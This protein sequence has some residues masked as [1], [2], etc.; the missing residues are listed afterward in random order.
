MHQP[1]VEGILR[2]YTNNA[3]NGPRWSSLTISTLLGVKIAMLTFLQNKKGLNLYIQMENKTALPYLMKM[4]GTKKTFLLPLGKEIWKKI[5]GSGDQSYRRITSG[6][7]KC[8]SRLRILEPCGF[9]R[10]EI[11]LASISENNIDLFPTRDR[12]VCNTSDLWNSKMSFMEARPQF[13]KGRCFL[14]VLRKIKGYAF[15][16]FSLIDSFQNKIGREKC[17]SIVIAPGWQTQT[18]YTILLNMSIQS[19]TLLPQIENLLTNDQGEI[20]SLVQRHQLKLVRLVVC[21]ISGN[22]FLQ[23]DYRNWLL[24]LFKVTDKKVIS[25]NMDL[26]GES[27]VSKTFIL[28]NVILTIQQICFIRN[29]NIIL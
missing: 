16:P 22:P 23:Q 28:F 7:V 14:T 9:M 18:L 15:P 24:N 27:Y 17:T 10:L 26:P 19:P 2:R 20:Y 12:S 11:R 25:L 29:M 6:Q 8:P 3:G 4:G 1:K 13:P 21:T 5:V